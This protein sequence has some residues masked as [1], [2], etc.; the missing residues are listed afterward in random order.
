[1][2]IL[3][4]VG[5]SSVGAVGINGIESKIAI[6]PSKICTIGR[7]SLGGLCGW[8]EAARRESA[9]AR[10][11]AKKSIA[12]VGGGVVTHPHPPPSKELNATG[13]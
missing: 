7:P 9:E 3:S 2:V 11:F 4:Y 12:S 8:T 13:K 1:M 6:R 10:E 5:N